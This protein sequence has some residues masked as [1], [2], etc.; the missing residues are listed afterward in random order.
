MLNSGNFIVDSQRELEVNS[1]EV[2][3]FAEDGKIQTR[4]L[5][6]KY[7]SD[8]MQIQ[9]EKERFKNLVSSNSD[10]LIGEGSDASPLK[11]SNAGI[12]LNL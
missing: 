8:L 5:A 2:A 3:E 10:I 1:V 11:L 6:E 7:I 9:V 4:N 12:N